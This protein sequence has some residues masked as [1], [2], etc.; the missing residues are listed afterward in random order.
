[1]VKRSTQRKSLPPN[2]QSA[3]AKG[4]IFS[5]CVRNYSFPPRSMAE[6]CG[7]EMGPC[8][9]CGAGE[10]CA[11]CGGGACDCGEGEA[12]AEEAPATEEGEEPAF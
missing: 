10:K 8:P 2:Y 9:M 6:C 3:I 5:E 4:G 1:M 7:Q 12:P 11:M